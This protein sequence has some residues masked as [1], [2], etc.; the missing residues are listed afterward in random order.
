M[1]EFGGESVIL[2]EW[3]RG[4]GGC[5][6]DGG[7]DSTAAHLADSDREAGRRTAEVRAI[8]KGAKHRVG[9]TTMASISASRG[10]VNLVRHAV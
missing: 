3:V 1:V 9:T 5:G 8:C 6:G 4:V 10:D 7:G 2:R